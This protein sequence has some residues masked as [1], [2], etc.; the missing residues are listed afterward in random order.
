MSTTMIRDEALL[1]VADD[2]TVWIATPDAPTDCWS[3]RD[4]VLWV[5]SR[6][7]RANVTLFRPPGKDVRAAWV[8]HEQI[9]R[10]AEL[11]R[12]ADTDAA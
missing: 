2:V 12:P 6:A 3:L 7:D 5:M 9:R 11:L 1:E 8:R 10:L 4:A